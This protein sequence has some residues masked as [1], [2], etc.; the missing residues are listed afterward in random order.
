MGEITLLDC[1]T[2]EQAI[3]EVERN[4]NAKLPAKVAEFRLLT[5][6]CLRIVPDPEAEALIA[7]EGQ[8]D[9]KDL[10][11]LVAALREKCNYLLTFN[12]RHYFPPSEALLIQRPGEFLQ[13]VRGM[14]SQM[15]IRK[16]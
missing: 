15:G 11:L 7:H 1:V 10:P 14:I 9:P 2:S 6:R 16:Q 12:T 8:A 5:S 13:A 3:T 4:L